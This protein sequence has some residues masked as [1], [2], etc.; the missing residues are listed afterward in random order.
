M[1]FKNKTRLRKE[2]SPVAA[3]AL[4]V[5][6]SNNKKPIGDMIE[7]RALDIFCMRKAEDTPEGLIITVKEFQI[8]EIK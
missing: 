4:S 7:W 3:E 6:H 1:M 8:K 5:L 2:L